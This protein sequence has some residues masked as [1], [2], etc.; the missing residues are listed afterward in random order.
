MF[1]F[2]A[3]KVK[4]P[5]TFIFEENLRL[6]PSNLH[7]WAGKVTCKVRFFLVYFLQH[8]CSIL[9]GEEDYCARIFECVDFVG[10]TG[11]DTYTKCWNYVIICLPRL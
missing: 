9:E 6:N 7:F 10:A 5:V 8:K 4:N 1:V 2:R 3:V 11:P